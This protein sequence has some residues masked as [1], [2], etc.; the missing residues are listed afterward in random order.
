VGVD[1]ATGL[2]DAAPIVSF[3]KSVGQPVEI[4]Q[5]FISWQYGSDP[6]FS[7]FPTGRVHALLAAGLLPEITWNPVISGGSARDEPSM[8][9]KSIIDGS[10]DAY[11]R[12]FA[13]AAA[14]IRAPVLLRFGSDMNLGENSYA[15]AN[16]GNRPGQFVKAWRLVWSIFRQVGAKNVQWVWSP[17]VGSS[18]RTLK[19]LYPGN[20]YVT[21]VGLDGDS[22]PPDDC[23]A[24]SKLFGSSLGEVESLSSRPIMLAEVGISARC[25]DKASLISAMFGWF[26]T[27][28]VIRSFTWLQRGTDSVA[29]SSAALAAF[30][31][32]LSEWRPLATGGPGAPTTTT[33][34]TATGTG[35]STSTESTSSTS[36]STVSSPTSSTSA[37]TVGSPTSSTSATTATTPAT[38]APAGYAGPTSWGLIGD[39]TTT[40]AQEKAAGITSKIIRISWA[41][42]ETSPG[43]FSASYEASKQ[44][45]IASLES[46]GMKVIL[47][48]GLQGTPSW[49]HQYP[50][51][52]L[53]NQ[54]GEPWTSSTV[55]GQTVDD[56]TANLVFNSQLR[57]LAAAYIDQVAQDFGGTAQAIRIGGGV[58]GELDYPPAST[59][60]HTNDYWAFDASAQAQSPV[61][62]WKPGDGSPNGQA[63]TFLNWYLNSLTTFEDWQISTLRSAYPGPIIVLFPGWGIRPGQT[64][65][66][67]ADNLDGQSGAESTGEIPRA[68]DFV[69]Q[70]AA[71]NQANVWAETTWL[72]A[73][74]YGS[75]SSTDPDEWTPVHYL[76]S[77]VTANPF[78]PE[79]WGENTGEGSTS[80]MTYAIR[81]ACTYDVQGV[82]WYDENQLLSGT[83]ATLPNYKTAITTGCS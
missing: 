20:A 61:P 7:Q 24:V 53:Q 1:V 33:G 48:L 74:E 3:E 17:S 83:Y 73:P 59:P 27:E 43:V 31:T 37:S 9:L 77:L 62:G 21:W 46:A 44:A 52:Y 72:D 60:G 66:A 63:Q 11:I 30:R 4:V 81:Q 51:S 8:S 69:D 80:A 82:V 49:I 55:P 15:E 45:E 47:D 19:E 6:A 50:D 67:V 40:A 29:T 5:S 35:S 28:R 25:A 76:S 79:L 56:S 16:N 12:Q 32:G 10:H 2:D 41:D 68:D 57:T 78:H 64:A 34:S 38:T 13:R 75:D 42:F 18:A 23:P 26:R 70:V 58:D 22:N 71:I 36:T 54:Y 65:A 14:A 39:E